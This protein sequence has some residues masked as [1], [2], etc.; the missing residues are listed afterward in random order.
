MPSP[1]KES[2]VLRLQRRPVGVLAWSAA[3]LLAG[4]WAAL[5]VPLEWSPTVELPQVT[6]S[7]SWPGSSPRA[8]ERYVT[9]PIERA[10]AG[11]AGTE[12]IES[13]SADGVSTVRVSISEDTNG[14]V[15]VAQLNE[16]LAVLRETLPDRVWPNLTKQ[17]PASLRDEQGF[18][19]LQV[20][21]PLALDELR[22][23]TERRIKPRLQS[24]AGIAEIEITGGTDRELLIELNPDR[25]SALGLGPQDV[26]SPIRELTQDGAYGRL[27]G[28]GRSTLLMRSP[29]EAVAGYRDLVL[30]STAGTSAPVRLSDV[31]R[32]E[33]GPA[34][35]R[36]ISR[37]DG[38]PVVA[39]RIDRAKASNLI[40]VAEGVFSAIEALRAELPEDVRV[41]VAQDKSED[42]RAQLRDIGWKGGLG[43]V[44]VV[45]VL[46]F[47]LKSVQATLVVLFSVG[48][49]ISVAFLL[50]GPAGL[51]LNLL[52]IAGLV[53]VFGL[54][55]DNAVVVVEQLIHYRGPDAAE[56]AIQ[57]VWLPLVGGTLSTMVVM[58]PLVYLSGE[59]R[60]LFLPFG[61]LTCFV[62]AA[63]L[64]TAAIVV[65]VA[66]RFLE[67]KA[68]V[69]PASRRLR[70]LVALPY[71]LVARFPKTS[72][73]AV[74]LLLGLPVWLFP[75]QISSVDAS[76]A[77]PSSPGYRL[78]TVYN[79]AFDHPW[80]RSVRDWTDPALGGL[81]R[82]FSREVT[83]GDRWRPQ[84]RPSVY[85]SLTFPPG[86]PI[87]RADSLMQVFEREA[88]ASPSVYRAIVNVSESRASLRLQ[89]EEADLQ[90]AEPYLLRERLISHAVNT[91]GIR[92]SVGGLIPD[93]YYSGSGSSISGIRLEAL[94]PSYEDLDAMLSQFATYIS[95]RS[96]RVAAVETNSSRYGYS[97]DQS[98]QV[99]RF[100]WTAESQARSGVSSGQLAAA[101]RPVF[102]A[103]RPTSYV[104]LEGDVQVPIRIAVAGANDIDIERLIRQPFPATDSLSVQLATLADYRVIDRPASIERID[105]RYLRH[106]TIDFR[107]PGQMANQFIETAL[108]GYAVP[109]GYDLKRSSFSFFTEEVKKQ[110]TWVMWATIAL[111]FLITAAVFESWTLPLIV[112]LSVPTAGIGV[113]LGF[114]WTEANFAE[115]AFI[116]AILMVGIAVNDS[117]LLVD[118]Y[119]QL[120]EGSP[121]LRPS[122]AMRLAVRERLRPMI[123]TTLTSVVTML[124]LIVFPSDTDFWQG[125]AVTVIGGLTASTLFA[126]LVSVAAVAATAPSRQGETGQPAYFH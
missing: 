126:P 60:A 85:V 87:A 25:L 61:V 31:A 92:I 74:I 41:L 20:I 113:S 5:Q 90:T 38:N 36:S 39:I 99:L 16:Q 76:D 94:G 120:R 28:A 121:G 52:T 43:L 26:E 9:A 32:I 62:L 6:V 123:T 105:Q 47:M 57:T 97:Y 49:S 75:R 18:M 50:L 86:H 24:I 29:E 13:S 7:A 84:D 114:L 93:G 35:V 122:V 30:K 3:L 82:K 69:R 72:L 22:D 21:G 98:R 81:M 71:K 115:G 55:V 79:A 64:A 23:L 4:A 104:D 54:L 12:S 46:L 77:D 96:R 88:L 14:G 19:L 1:P 101:L 51:S 91:G 8:V 27:R 100:D 44:L 10:I 58:L 2:L 34:P 111:V 118:R 89:F 116:G 107:G 117:I 108:E 63:S 73:T 56:R 106:V 83:F 80:V 70:R 125:L 109:V 17:I 103:D 37:I 45:F 15:Y 78:A 48:V 65:P 59:L 68:P 40:D 112:M 124:P 11:V 53:L 67:S 95:G 110:F 102:R 66:G 33:M 119:R 42:I